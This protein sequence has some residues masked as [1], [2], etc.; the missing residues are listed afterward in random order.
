[1]RKN[2]RQLIAYSSAM[3]LLFLPSLALAQVQTAVAPTLPSLTTGDTAQSGNKGGSDGDSV[4][5]RPPQHRTDSRMMGPEVCMTI[6]K[7]NELHADGFDIGPDGSKVSLE[8]HLG[9]MSH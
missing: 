8:K 1:M 3:M 4:Y 7:W 5:C 6:Q 9:M 2:T